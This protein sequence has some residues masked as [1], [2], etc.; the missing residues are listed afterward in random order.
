MTPAE[1]DLVLPVG[2]ASLLPV[3]GA[4]IDCPIQTT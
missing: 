3:L 4:A 2:V 1:V